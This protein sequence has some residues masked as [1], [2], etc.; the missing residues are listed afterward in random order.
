M[1]R[2]AAL[3]LPL[4]LAGCIYSFTGGGLPGHVDTVAVVA[5]DNETPEPLLETEVQRALQNE[6]PRQL[7]VRLAEESL[8]DAVVRGIIRSYSEAPASVRPS[9]GQQEPAPVVQFEIRITYDVE[10]YDRTA[11]QIIWRSQGQTVT[12]SFN[13]E[14]GEG[15]QDGKTRAIEELVRKVIEGAQSQW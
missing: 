4:L 6:L 8:A 3:S 2:L 5:L 15:V 14:A 1:G 9:Q 10:I 11:D 13:P 12:G 7:G